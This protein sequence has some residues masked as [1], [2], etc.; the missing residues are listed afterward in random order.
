MT[1][2]ELRDRVDSRETFLAFLK[3]LQRDREEELAKE[4]ASPSSPWGPGHHGWENGS[5]EA[6]LDAMHAW[7]VDSNALPAEPTW[8]AIAQLFSAGKHYE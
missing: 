6:F 2:E 7:A 5:I 3:S 1:P 4:A 8:R